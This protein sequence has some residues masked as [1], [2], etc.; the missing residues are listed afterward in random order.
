MRYQLTK[1][2]E[3]GNMII[4]REHR[5]LLDTVNK[6]MDAC[7]S[8]SGRASVES[9]AK[10]LL[11]YVD[12]HFAHEEDLQ[13]KSSYPGYSSH[14]LFHENYK[15]KLKE[16]VSGISANVSIADLSALTTQIGILVSHIRTEDKKLAEFLKDSKRGR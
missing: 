3:T 7:S 11:S 6:L 5:E 4:D 8:G 2:L 12:Q 10:F 14:R 9:V 13:K 1:D 16:I 15:R